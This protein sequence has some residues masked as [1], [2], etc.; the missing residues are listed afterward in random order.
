MAQD[1]TPKRLQIAG[2]A[3]DAATEIVQSIVALREC[4]YDLSQ[5]GG[6]FDDADFAS[7][8]PHLD[9]ATINTLLSTG[10]QALATA[11]ATRLD[12]TDPAS[13]TLDDV[14]RRVKRGS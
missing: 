8:Y 3:V 11:S 12:P 7:S 4:A 6:A 1:F 13:A 2:R 9:A 14:M 10:I 5:T